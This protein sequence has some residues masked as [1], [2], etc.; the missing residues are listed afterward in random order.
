MKKITLLFSVFVLLTS[1]CVWLKLPK[2]LENIFKLSDAHLVDNQEIDMP[3]G[4]NEE[5]QKLREAWEHQMLADPATGEIPEGIGFAEQLFAAGLPK[6]VTERNSSWASR[7]PWNVGGRTRALAIDVTNENRILAG[8]V[9]GGIWLSEDA[10]Q[11]WTRKT[12]INAHPG[13]VSIAQDTR[14]GH[15]N[16]WYYLSGEVSGNSTTGS[17]NTSFYFGDGIFKSTDGGNTWA[18]LSATAGGN[19]QAFTTFYQTGYRVV[20]SPTDSLDVVYMA[21]L[22]AI[23]RSANGGASWTQVR[24]GAFTSNWSYYTDVTTTTTGVL[25][26]T[27]SSD[28]PTK[29]IWR[30]DNGTTWKNI[31]PLDTA[32]HFPTTY[33]RIVMGV[34][35]NNENEVYFLGST[36]GF[37]FKNHYISSD[38]WSSLWKYTYISGDGTGAG[39]QWVNLTGNLPSVGTEF[40]RFSCQGGY[41]LVVKVQPGTNHVFIGGTNIYR[42][43][44]GFTTNTNTTHIGGYAPGTYLPFFQLY[45]NH[46]PDQHD[47]LFLPSDPNIMLNAS[48]GGLHRTE[49]CNAATVA[50]T[51][52]NRGYTT[53]QFYT[54]VIDKSIAGDNTLI[55][56]LQDNG[57]FFV[58]STDP[59]DIWKQVLNGDGAYGA[60]PD[61]KPYYILSIQQGRVSK[62]TIDNQGNVTAFRRIDPIGPKKDDYM[63][64]NPLALDPADQKVLYLPAGRRLYRQD[65]LNA[66]ALTGAWDSIAQGWTQFPDTLLAANGDFS[67]IG[68]S[69]A[70][71]S[72]RVFVGTSKNKIYRIDDANVGTPSFTLLPSPIVSNTSAYINCIAVDPDNADDVMV[73][74]SNYGIYSLF[75]SQNGGQTWQKVGG[76]IE[77]SSSGS[78][79]GP[80][81]RWLS[82]LP[83]PDGSRK[84]FCGT[85]VG[86]FSTDSLKLHT[87][88]M[89]GTQWALEAPDLIGTSVVPFVDVRPVDGLVVAATHGI[90][91]FSANFAPFVGSQEPSSASIVKAW[92]NPV[93]SDLHFSVPAKGLEPVDLLLFDQ[94]GRVVLRSHWSGE[95]GQV[96]LNGLPSGTYY[97]SVSGKGWKKSGKV[98]KIE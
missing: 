68:V 58:N 32:L 74:Y 8:G 18:P 75:R 80:S 64:I 20:T 47:L 24:G 44:D 57:N 4:E 1:A 85:S 52:L 56:G 88:N 28:G 82:I 79:S 16:T 63:F 35:P 73:V 36:P 98:L 55:G 21:T 22:G 43:T 86:L 83:F 53:S 12:P 2:H 31:I 11:T 87:G 51:K 67:A 84:Y 77:N 91:M 3:G 94:K 41:D 59:N 72:H 30:S 5:N 27:L 89:P 10:G 42:S 69:K 37:G 50:W 34:N 15:T 7:G 26:A 97:Y 95:T 81:V 65:D 93:Q 61:G 19:P 45:T 90:G 62:S 71:P 40:D 13:C 60:I 6:A 39:G 66:I 9:S 92:P 17:S 33:D 38:D 70:N 54:A 49:D 48:D 76:N 78:G 25:Y 14:D 23:Y 29:G 96:A 46:H